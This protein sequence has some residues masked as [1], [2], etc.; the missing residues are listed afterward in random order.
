MAR[1]GQTRKQA[2]IY[3]YARKE[4]IPEFD[5]T[6]PK[7]DQTAY[8]R[9][10]DKF[11]YPQKVAFSPYQDFEVNLGISK[12]EEKELI[13]R[14]GEVISGLN[15]EKIGKPKTLYEL[16]IG[17]RSEGNFYDQAMSK[18]YVEMAPH[19]S[20]LYGDIHQQAPALNMMTD[21]QVYKLTTVFK[22]DMIKPKTET[23][24]KI[25]SVAKLNTPYER[26]KI[27]VANQNSRDFME[28]GL[29]KILVYPSTDTS[30]IN[31]NGNGTNI[32]FDYS[33]ELNKGI[34]P[35]T[36]SQIYQ[37][38]FLN[39]KSVSNVN[40]YQL[41]AEK[42]RQTLGLFGNRQHLQVDNSQEPRL[43]DRMLRPHKYMKTISKP[44]QP[45]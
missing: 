12:D 6:E 39:P 32:K 22:P 23:E 4:Y 9:P 15:F 17:S 28:S 40:M 8:Q 10:H 3:D 30:L 7:F 14:R 5:L 26:E 44:V 20:G 41:D 19:I 42:A 24:K 37:E 1:I 31:G 35:R 25:E 45:Q 38:T 43:T 13:R 36:A 11:L 29:G 18:P 21:E 27:N 16:K 2:Q 34:E 33:K